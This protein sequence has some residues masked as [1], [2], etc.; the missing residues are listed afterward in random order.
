MD[1]AEQKNVLKRSMRKGRGSTGEEA[2]NSGR[3][4]RG[5][6]RGEAANEPCLETGMDFWFVEEL[7]GIRGLTKVRSEGPACLGITQVG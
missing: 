7:T 5:G 1:E 6:P 4:I 2:I 3:A